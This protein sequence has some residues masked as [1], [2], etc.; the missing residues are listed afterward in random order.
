M[1]RKYMECIDD[2]SLILSAIPIFKLCDVVCGGECCAIEGFSGTAQRQ[3][4]R[5]I[6]EF[7]LQY[8][9]GETH[10]G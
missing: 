3:C 9:E 2:V 4:Q 1:D 7:L 6:K 5:K 10:D 8:V